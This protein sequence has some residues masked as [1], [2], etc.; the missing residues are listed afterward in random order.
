VVNKKFYITGGIG[1]KHEGEAFGKNY[2]LPNLTAYNETCAAIANVF[3]NFRMFLLHGDAKYIDVMERSLYNNV[4]SGIG[5]DGKTFFYPNPLQCDMLYKFNSGRTLDRQ[6]WFDCSCCPSNDVRIIASIPGYVY[7]LKDNDVFAN[8]YIAGNADIQVGGKKIG[9]IQE[10][11]YPWDGKITFTIN[12]DKEAD[13]GLNLRIPCWSVNQVLPGDLYAFPDISKEKPAI[14]VNGKDLTFST[15]KGY[16]RI[17]RSWKKG[18]RVELILPMPVRKVVANNNV[19][20]DLRKVCLIRG[21]ITYC[22]EQIDNKDDVLKLAILS[23]SK[24]TVTSKPG[25]LTGAPVIT[26]KAMVINDQKTGSETETTL[27]AVPYCLWDNRGANKM[28]VWFL[29]SK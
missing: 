28:N 17:S 20:D 5:L 23:P 12:P 14:R 19:K 24:F 22:A 29:N 15:V 26:A 16:A 13:F 9:M 27:T 18:D 3:W 7:A 11:R 10:S 4:V 25:I 6:P 21:P 1:A 8:L 2:E